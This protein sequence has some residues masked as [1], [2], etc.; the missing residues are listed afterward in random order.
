MAIQ[1]EHERQKVNVVGILIGIVIAVSL[2][3][4]V[5]FFLFKRPE[6]IDVVLPNDLQ[7]LS[8]ISDIPFQPERVFSSEKYKALREYGGGVV[9]PQTGKA[10]P[11][12]P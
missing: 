2:F 12:L 11:F 9:E 7:N 4:G 8:K 3:A 6:I 10:N 5:Y 1:I